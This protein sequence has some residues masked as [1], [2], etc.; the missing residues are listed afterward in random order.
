MDL[1]HIEYLIEVVKQG[2]FSRAAETLHVSQSAISKLIKDLETN[3]DAVLLKRS[4]RKVEL[5]D[6]GKIVYES[7][8]MLMQVVRNIYSQLEDLKSSS[9]GSIQIGIYP[10]LSHVLITEMNAAFQAQFPDT[11]IRFKEGSV[12]GLKQELIDG[13][14]DIALL[15]FPVEEDRLNGF[16]FFQT[17]MMLIAHE[18]HPLAAKPSVHW[19]ELD[20]EP[21]IIAQ[22][23]FM[24]HHVLMEQFRKHGVSPR[25]MCE[26][27]QWYFMLD[28]VAN[29]YGLTILPQSKRQELE[30]SIKS[31]MRIIPLEPN[32]AWKFGLC[33]LKNEY[34]TYSARAWI[35]FM[36]QQREA[37][38]LD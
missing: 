2:G 32:Y 5:T 11:Q 36:M 31:N 15:P 25:I 1:R 7:G 12:Q 13:D 18:S 33:W 24:L 22:D 23:S 30:G 21:F 6:A 20:Q 29:Q 35:N 17:D 37:Y 14:I 16:L 38:L 10:M 3:L 28:L 4:T 9:R 19:K 26:A 8:L 27:T 34:L